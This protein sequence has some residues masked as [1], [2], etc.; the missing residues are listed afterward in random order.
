MCFVFVKELDLGI[1]SLHQCLSVL[2]LFWIPKPF[3]KCTL[4][5]KYREMTLKKHQFMGG[6]FRQSFPL[7]H[8]DR[9]LGLPGGTGDA[10]GT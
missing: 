4:A 9:A 2:N 7:L 6:S 1:S 5:E 10:G 8:A 3:K